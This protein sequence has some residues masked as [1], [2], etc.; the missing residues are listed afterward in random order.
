MTIS[1]EQLKR[2]IEGALLAAGEPLPL[3]QI[4]NLFAETERPSLDELRAAV[5]ELETEYED[6]GFMLKEV[7]SGYR[8]QV[9]EELSPWIIRLWEEKPARYSR[10]LLETLVLIAYRQPI[11]R[12]EIEEV[13]GVSVSSHIVKTLIEREWVRVVGHR[14]VPGKPA[15]LATTKQFLDYFNLKSLDELPTLEEIQDLDVL[16]KQL[17][18]EG[19][20]P[21][22]EVDA[23]AQDEQAQ[24]SEDGDAQAADDVENNLT[25]EHDG[26]EITNAADTESDAEITEIND[27]QSEIAVNNIDE[28]EVNNDIVENRA[29]QAEDEITAAANEQIMQAETSIDIQEFDDT[30]DDSLAYLQDEST[31]FEYEN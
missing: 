8:L 21:Q 1:K 17:E 14:D 9:K 7:A 5:S 13:R 23:E 28:L 3:E 26:D 18:L 25:D 20:D 19:L 12:A 2:I 29:G 31:E 30:E 10:A 16:A 4:R 24:V 22:A 27:E 6:H 15:L 11:T